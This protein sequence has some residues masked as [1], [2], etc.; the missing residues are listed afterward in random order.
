MGSL[1]GKGRYWDKSNSVAYICGV[2]FSRKRPTA[3]GISSIG[4]GLIILS[5]GVGSSG[6][7]CGISMKKCY[8]SVL[9]SVLRLYYKLFRVK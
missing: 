8:V 6:S 2:F 5:L 7:N 4:L 9:I 1:T 3:N